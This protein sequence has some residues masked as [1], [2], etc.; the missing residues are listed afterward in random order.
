F[1]AYDDTHGREVWISDGSTS[2]T[3]RVTNLPGVF[4]TLFKD[5]LVAEDK[6]FFTT[7]AGIHGDLWSTD[8]TLEGTQQLAEELEIE[9][10]D[11]VE[12]AVIL[13]NKIIFPAFSEENGWEPWVSDG[14]VEG[15]HILK[16]INP[17]NNDAQPWGNS[18]PVNFVVLGDRVLF[19]AND[20]MYNNGLWATDGTTNGTYLVS[21]LGFVKDI[22]V[23]GEFVLFKIGNELWKTDGT[24]DETQ[25][26]KL[27]EQTLTLQPSR[28]A[29]LDDKLLFW[30]EDTTSGGEIWISD[31]Y[32]A[33]TH[34]LKDIWLGSESSNPSSFIQAGD[35]VFFQARDEVHG[36]GTWVTKGTA[37]STVFVVSHQLIPPYAVAAE[38]SVFYTLFHRDPADDGT[39]TM[40]LWLTDGTPEGTHLMIEDSER[41]YLSNLIRSLTTIGHKAFFTMTNAQN[42]RYLWVSE[43]S[44]ETTKPLMPRLSYTIHLAITPISATSVQLDWA[45]DDPSCVYNI[46]R[47]TSPKRA[48][49]QHLTHL[50]KPPFE[51]AN[52]SNSEPVSYFYDLEAI[53]SSGVTTAPQQ[54]GLFKFKIKSGS[55]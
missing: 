3:S 8:G 35:Q 2:G 10:N 20:A 32:E 36:A 46:Y 39:G 31:G 12:G 5:L 41:D 44:P 29:V 23:V 21:E 4:A 19:A 18:Y 1:T 13:D 6:L 24:V 42:K 40:E 55:P 15:T 14:T 27:F 34:L 9:L 38:D 45:D 54:A 26:V 50:D 28:T 11:S 22:V 30:A 48:H 51:D 33:G 52:I 7:A 37:A 49:L 43:G 17:D 47:G 16:E 25:L 53:C